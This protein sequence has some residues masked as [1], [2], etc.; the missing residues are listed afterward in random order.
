MCSRSAA[1]PKCSSSPASQ[2]SAVAEAPCPPPGPCPVHYLLLCTCPRDRGSSMSPRQSVPDPARPAT[3]H[4]PRPGQGP[5][6]SACDRRPR[7]RPSRAAPG[8]RRP[9]HDD[10]GRSD[11]G[12]FGD[13]P[14]MTRMTCGRARHATAGKAKLQ[15]GDRAGI[16]SRRHGRASSGGPG[17][18]APAGAASARSRPPCR[19]CFRIRPSAA[20]PLEPGNRRPARLTASCGSRAA[21]SAS[22]AATPATPGSPHSTTT[23]WPPPSRVL[24]PRPHTGD[25]LH[26]LAARRGPDPAANSPDVSPTIPR[27][28]AA[29]ATGRASPPRPAARPAARP[30]V[31]ASLPVAG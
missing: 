23:T 25:R 10:A 8:S 20:A 16:M 27:T 5:S 14:M 2:N 4:P 3:R 21:A 31:P 12:D 15:R 7:G 1:R 28:P 22:A 26:A 11:S 29:V 18:A 24:R 9:D 13:K 30:P 19:A 6:S 17:P